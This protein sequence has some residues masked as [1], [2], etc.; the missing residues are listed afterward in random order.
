MERLKDLLELIQD[1]LSKWES[2]DSYME[3]FIN[4][5]IIALILHDPHLSKHP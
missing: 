4:F 2:R 3:K 5:V 1:L